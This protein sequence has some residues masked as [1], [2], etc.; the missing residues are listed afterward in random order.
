MFTDIRSQKVVFIAHCLLNQNSISDG[1]AVYPAAFKDMIQMFLDADVG[2]VQMPCPELCCLG[3]DRGN[4]RGA[5]SPVVVENTRIRREMQKTDTYEKLTYLVD[6]V[7]RQLMEYQKYGFQILGIIGANRSPNCGIETTSECNQETEGMGLFM[8]ALSRRLAADNLSIPMLGIK[9]S[10]N[11]A[12]KV[13][14]LL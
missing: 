8:E 1:T 9:G 7:M 10:D 5:D 12:E 4:I 3:L 11:V 13:K 6:Y 14:L 2:I